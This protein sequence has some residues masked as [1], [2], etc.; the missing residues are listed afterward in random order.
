MVSLLAVVVHAYRLGQL[1]QLSTDLHC[2][3]VEGTV[4]GTDI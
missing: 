3:A 2:T 4:A 1:V